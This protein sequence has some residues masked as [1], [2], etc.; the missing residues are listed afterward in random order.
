MRGTFARRRG[1][2]WDPKF[3][4]D[5]REGGGVV[6]FPGLQSAER[7]DGGRNG[8]RPMPSQWDLR[9]IGIALWLRRLSRY[10]RIDERR[11]ERS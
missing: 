10:G 5:P 9:E 3:D 11:A 6:P 4:P 7:L 1:L 2:R 8:I